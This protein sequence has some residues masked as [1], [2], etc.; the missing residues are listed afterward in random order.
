MFNKINQQEIVDF[1]KNLQIMLKGGI[2]INEALQSL[3]QQTKSKHFRRA[4]FRAAKDVE[5]GSSFSS[6][7]EKERRIFGDIYISLI[8]AG[9]ASGT[10]E[11][12]LRYLNSWLERNNDLKKEISAAFMYPKIVLTI[13][14][15]VGGGLATIILP[16]LVP[17]FKNL[18]VEL[19]PITK[20]L[21]AVSVFLQN[22]W[23]AI[24]LGAAL[25]IVG[26]ILI[27]KIKTVRSFLHAVYL[28]IP[29]FGNFISEYQLA[30]ISYLLHTLFKSGLAIQESVNIAAE[31]STNLKY[32]EAV[33]SIKERIIMGVSLSEAMR[34]Y[35]NIFP[36]NFINIVAVGEKSGALDESFLN[37]ADFYSKEVSDKTKKIPTVI[38]PILLLI[39]GVLVLMIALSIILPI[40]QL[41]RGIK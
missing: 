20:A 12:N 13:A 23:Y 21:I 33:F 41:T 32:K 25:V 36:L 1:T 9:E 37:L 2:S 4:I 31:A 27:N 17:L 5:M 16:R 11:D 34:D 18:R 22:Y 6:A 15:L 38:E 26:F 29:F 14:F 40:Y 7:L 35:P 30:L 3:S 28:K 8:K 39:I 10:L 19:P 24:F